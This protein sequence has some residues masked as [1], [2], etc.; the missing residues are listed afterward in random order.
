MHRFYKTFFLFLFSFHLLYSFDGWLHLELGAGN[1]GEKGDP[2]DHRTTRPFDP[3][4]Q[5]RV[6]F[7]TVDQLIERYGPSG[8]IVLN[9]SNIHSLRYAAEQLRLYNEIRGY[10]RIEIDT[11][12]G[13]YF[14]LNPKNLLESYSRKT[15]DTIHLKNPDQNFFGVTARRPLLG[16]KSR[17]KTR[18]DL[19]KIANFGTEGLYLF[20]LEEEDYIPVEERTD[21]M[22]KEIFYEKTDSW[23]PV[24]YHYPTGEKEGPGKVFFI[25]SRSA[26]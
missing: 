25:R 26:L 8:I 12:R 10:D 7:N 22:E 24:E 23:E 5:Y 15:F 17:A 16:E 9:D 4:V 13:N 6:L 19:Q 3:F 14:N 18:E 2:Q 21:F 1:Y 20:I 11:I